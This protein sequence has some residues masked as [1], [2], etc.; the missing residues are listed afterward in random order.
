LHSRGDKSVSRKKARV[1]SR[2]TAIARATAFMFAKDARTAHR[3]MPRAESQLV[4]NGTSRVN[5]EDHALLR[6][7][8]FALEGAHLHDHP[9]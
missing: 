9:R 1:A 4:L 8:N 2:L 6:E 5:R 7:L 3:G